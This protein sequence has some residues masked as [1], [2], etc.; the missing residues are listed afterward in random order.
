MGDRMYLLFLA[1]GTVLSALVVRDWRAVLRTRIY[2]RHH[3]PGVVSRIC[4]AAGVSPGVF[5][6]LQALFLL[7]AVLAGLGVHRHLG[8]VPTSLVAAL[9]VLLIPA[10]ALAAL[11]VRRMLGRRQEIELLKRLF[12]LNGSVQPVSCEEVIG[13]L[14]ENAHYLKP[15]FHELLE[16]RSRNTSS[17]QEIYDRLACRHRELEIRL[18]LEKLRQADCLNLTDGVE[19]L[20]TDLVLQTMA[21]RRQAERIRELIGLCGIA[22]GVLLAG[23][24]TGALLIPWLEVY[25]LATEL[26]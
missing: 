20:K 7:P 26:W 12:V 14:C 2:T 17:L 24:L 16:E 6:R 13:I 22:F 4:R 25:S 18:F 8:G 3:P 21:R 1:G 11:Y 10:G 5:I 19:S 23:F 9:A 15:V